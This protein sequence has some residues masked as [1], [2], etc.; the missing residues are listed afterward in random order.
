MTYSLDFRVKVLS[1]REAENLT[2]SDVSTRFGVGIAT[3]VRWLRRIEPCRTRIKPTSKIN[4][5][6]LVRDVREH[7]DSYLFERAIRF[8]VSGQ[9]I[10]HALRRMN[11]TVKKNTEPSKGR[12]RKSAYISG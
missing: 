7:P 5:I 2:I 12:R 6:D 3:V 9:G 10:A 8:G 4:M 11:I 1:V